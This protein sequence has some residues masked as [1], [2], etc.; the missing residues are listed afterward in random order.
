MEYPK[1]ASGSG[2]LH[3]VSINIDTTTI[4]IGV[5][6]PFTIIFLI[7]LYPHYRGILTHPPEPQG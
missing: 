6:I 7:S 2:F 3:A 4:T 5:T 1:L